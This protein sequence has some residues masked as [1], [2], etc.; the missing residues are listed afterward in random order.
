M[1]SIISCFPHIVNLACK[2]VISA[3]TNIDYAADDAPEFSPQHSDQDPIASIRAIVRAIQILETLKEKNLQLLQDVVTHW[4]STFLMIER[5]TLLRNAIDHFLSS[6]KF[7]ELRHLCLESA[8]WD[9]INM[10]KKIL[11]VPH[12]FQQKLSGEATPTLSGAIPSFEAVIAR[13]KQMKHE[14]VSM[15]DVIQEG[16]EKL[17]SY[18]ERIS[19]IPAYTLAM[20]INPNIKL[21]WHQQHARDRV[22]AIKEM[23]ITEACLSA[24]IMHNRGLAQ[25]QPMPHAAY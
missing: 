18:M 19:D 2:A 21:R 5:A 3:V 10:Y 20:I 25:S 22:G 4:S 23:F 1:V 16:I 6:N 11:E 14:M 12:A 9:L 7:P 13:W 24:Y 15:S 17:E 8:D